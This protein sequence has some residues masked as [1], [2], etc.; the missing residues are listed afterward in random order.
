MNA[1]KHG[2]TYLLA[3]SMVV[4]L[5]PLQGFTRQNS[6]AAKTNVRDNAAERDGQHDFDFEL[7]SWNIHLKRRLHPLTGSTT[8]VEFDGTSVTRK[9]WD[10]RSQLEEFETDSPV[11]GHIE[12]LTLRLYN[13][14]SHQWSLYW[15]NSNGGSIVPP[16]VGEFKNG[17][18]EFYGQ[19]TL[20]GKAIYIRF[21]WSATATN[22]P[23][24]EQSFSDDGGKTWEVNWIT[25]QT[26]I[27]NESDKGH[28]QQNSEAEKPGLQQAVRDGQHDFDFYFG[29]WKSH[30]S[31]LQ[32]PLTGSTTWVEFDGTIV[33]RKVWDGRANLDEFEAEG[34][35]G[36]IEGLT[37]RLYNPQTHQWSLYWANSKAGILGGPPTVGE[38]KNGRGEF[39]CQDTLNDRDILVRYVWSDITPN[40]AH[41]EQ[42]YSDDGGKTWE[43]NW[44]SPVTR[45]QG[46]SDK[47]H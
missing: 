40:S 43:V 11:A 16:Q 13:Q 26:R 45:V 33:T 44:I 22:T 34:P 15:A 7:G 41:F 35:T 1:L 29:A 3:C 32:H 37:L 18:G 39:F 46:E 36:H 42:S 10:G 9:V 23:H 14:Q 20:N 5:L 47:A 38:F 19:D 30:L 6:D 4:V 27:N 25:D 28:A 2:G 21:I 12:G 17:R 8:W 31:Q 24:F